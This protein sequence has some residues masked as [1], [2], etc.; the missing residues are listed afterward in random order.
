MAVALVPYVDRLEGAQAALHDLRPAVEAG[1]PWP[2]AER[3][4]TEPEASWGPPEVLAHLA[5]MLPYWYAQIGLVVAATGEPLPFG[6]TQ[7]D[8]RRIDAIEGDRSL[9]IAEL[10][11]RIDAGVAPYRAFLAGLSDADAARLG[12]H[13]TRGDIGILTMLDA[14]VVGHLEGHVAQLRTALE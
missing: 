9:P 7:E 3:F 11:D 6:R 8:A 12:R 10:F 14:L 4:G 2:L 13:P 5:E 1:E